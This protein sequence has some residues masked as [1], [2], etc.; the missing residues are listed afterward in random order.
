M[1][2]RTLWELD[3]DVSVPELMLFT[4]MFSRIKFFLLTSHEK[5]CFSCLRDS[6]L[7]YWYKSS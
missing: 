7:I 2:K 1:S 4:I 6:V 5:S 3:S